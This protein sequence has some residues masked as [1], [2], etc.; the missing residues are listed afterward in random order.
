MTQYLTYSELLEQPLGVEW[1]KIPPEL[2]NTPSPVTAAENYRQ[3]TSLI[4]RASGLADQYT[5][6]IL[7]ATL[8]TEEQLTD[9][10]TCGVDS[11]GFLWVHTANWPVISVQSLQYAYPTTGGTSWFAV[12]P[13]S[14]VIVGGSLSDNLMYPGFFYRR[15]TGVMRVQYTYLNG[16]PNST[17]TNTVATG[18]TALPLADA[19]GIIAGS[20]L[21]IYDGANTEVVTVAASWVP[22]LGPA[23]VT[24]ATGTVFSH[25]PVF[26]PVT[27]PATPY[28]I[29]VSAIPPEIKQAVGLICKYLVEFR[30]ATSLAASVS[31][32]RASSSKKSMMGMS[33]IPDAAAEVL[34]KFARIV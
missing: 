26:L 20:K 8:D 17:L 5:N 11:Q 7:A 22:I 34:D 24:L 1:R 6:Q 27:A 10:Y 21:T 3:V 23:N 2:P 19:T 31:G 25:T 4:Q 28:D 29:S 32:G 13:I 12:A 33:A 16:Y 18:V 9:G 14:D 15:G 30:G